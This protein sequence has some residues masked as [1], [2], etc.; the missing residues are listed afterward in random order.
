MEPLL[1]KAGI[2]ITLSTIAA[3]FLIQELFIKNLK[4]LIMAQEIVFK[5][6]S[7]DTNPDAYHAEVANELIGLIQKGNSNV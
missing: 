4:R 6:H 3:L 2:I 7:P 5:H 1:V